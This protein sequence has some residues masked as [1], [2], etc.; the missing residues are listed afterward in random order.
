MH[1]SM[2]T[3]TP[4]RG[5]N[6]PPSPVIRSFGMSVDH[7]V[8]IWKRKSRFYIYVWIGAVVLVSSDI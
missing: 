6:T 4:L 8:K 7:A 3:A 1:L 2:E 5:S